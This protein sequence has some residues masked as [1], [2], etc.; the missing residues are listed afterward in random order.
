MKQ[1]FMVLF[2]GFPSHHFPREIIKRLKI[3]L[4]QRS[5]IVF[6]SGWPLD[7]DR[8]DI[9]LESMY[10]MF[11]EHGLHFLSHSVIDNRMETSEAVQMIREA[12]C[13]F[14]MGGHPE[15]QLQFIRSK[16]LDTAIRA[17]TNAAILGVSAGAINMAK[18]SLGTTEFLAPYDG[19]GLGD[20]TIKPHFQLGDQQVVSSL[21]QISMELPIFAME[22]YSAIFVAD[23]TISFIGKIY[24]VNKGRIWYL[25][26]KYCNR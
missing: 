7:Y 4:T 2:S 11:S 10:N 26:R 25:S 17:N 20:I 12:S 9:R 22:D 15:S 16:G 23:S 8:N 21:L 14:L 3:E 6:V 1:R 19:L 24:C 13:I 18:R 5:S